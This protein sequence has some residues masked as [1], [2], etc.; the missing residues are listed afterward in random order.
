MAGMEEAGTVQLEGTGAINLKEAIGNAIEQLTLLLH[1]EVSSV[2]GA[3]K[4]EDGWH[5][6]IEL[7]ERKAIPDTQD[8]LG[9]YEVSLDNYGELTSYER[10]DMRRRMDLVET[11]E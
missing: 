9:T 5:L 4:S 6:T 2:V 10:I 1:L 8:L 7:I 11:A 3:R